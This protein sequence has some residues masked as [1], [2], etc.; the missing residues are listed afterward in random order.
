MQINSEQ[1]DFST[2]LEAAKNNHTSEIVEPFKESISELLQRQY[3]LFKKGSINFVHL[4]TSIKNWISFVPS[5]AI[6]ILNFVLQQAIA[7]VDTIFSLVIGSIAILLNN[8][9]SDITLSEFTNTI[10]M[11]FQLLKTALDVGLSLIIPDALTVIASIVATPMAAALYLLCKPFEL[12]YKAFGGNGNNDGPSRTY[13]SGMTFVGGEPMY[14]RYDAEIRATMEEGRRRRGRFPDD[15]DR[16]G[17]G[18]FAATAD[19]RRREEARPR[20]R[21]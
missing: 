6:A 21:F 8:I 14:P 11:P 15:G 9:N 17:T 16:M 3:S 1:N 4:I 5:A 10:T 18:Y 19:G 12:A 13:H 7:A 20:P 2:L